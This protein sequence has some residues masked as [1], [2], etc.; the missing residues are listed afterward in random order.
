MSTLDEQI[1]SQIRNIESATGLAMGDW[2][3]I[4]NESGIDTHAA[5][6]K[7]LKERHGL[8]HGNANLIV[9]RARAEA[10]G[11][12]TGGDAL[13]EAQYAGRNAVLRGLYDAVLAHVDNFGTDIE[14]SPKQKYVSLRRGK[15][16]AQVGPAAGTL[17]IGLNLPAAQPTDRLRP[18]PGMVT[19]RVRITEASELDAEPRAW[20]REAYDRA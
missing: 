5:A 10:A 9:T 12:P 6:V 7:M 17:E 15:Q 20:L 11:A 16:F 13:V 18:A 4:V 19:H 14:V 2:I 3:A 8:G 1:Q